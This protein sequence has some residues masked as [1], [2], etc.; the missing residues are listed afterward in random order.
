MAGTTAARALKALG[1]TSQ[2]VAANLAKRGV[3]GRTGAKSCPLANYLKLRGFTKPIVGRQHYW[4]RDGREPS[5]YLPFHLQVFV[6]KF[7]AGM[8]PELQEADL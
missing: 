1:P 3:K 4:L 2:A 7:D 8:Y 6:R 5:R